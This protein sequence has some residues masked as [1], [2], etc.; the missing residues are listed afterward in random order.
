MK[1]F[2]KT[3]R[4]ESALLKFVPLVFLSCVSGGLAMQIEPSETHTS[5]HV[6][7]GGDDANSGSLEQPV[8]TLNRASVLVR[9]QTAAGLTAPLHV[10]LHEG[11]YELSRPLNMGAEDGGTETHPVVWEA[12][13][14]ET[15]VI[16]GGRLV[17]GWTV[18]TDGLWRCALPD[19][20]VPE[21]LY[22]DGKAALRA[23]MPG[24]GKQWRLAKAEISPSNDVRMADGISLV[25]AEGEFENWAVS[26]RVDVVVFKDWSTFRQ[27][28]ERIEPAD[29]RVVLKP[30]FG[31]FTKKGRDHNGINVPSRVVN[32]YGFLEGHP[33][34]IDQPGDWAVDTVRKEVVYRPMAGQRPDTV[35]AVVPILETLISVRGEQDRPVRNLHFRGLGVSYAAWYL[36]PHGMDVQQAACNAPSAA[37]IRGDSDECTLPAA[38]H[39][40]YAETCTVRQC[41]VSHHGANG[42][43][44]AEGCR[45]VLVEKNTVFDLGAN[46][47]MIGT[48]RAPL[49]K[50]RGLL[51]RDISVRHN[52]VHHSGRA[53]PGAIGIWQ[54]F[55]YGSKI[56]HNHVHHLPYTGISIGWRWDDKRTSAGENRVAF[57]HIHDVMLELGDG[58]GIYTLG[59]QPGSTI[60]GN[61]IHAVRRSKLNSASPN[62][63]LYFDQGSRGISAFGNTVYDVAATPIRFHQLGG[64]RVEV[65]DNV[66]VS[67]GGQA[68]G[69]CSPPYD[70][71][72]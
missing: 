59:A 15:V 63:G 40:A 16:S 47:I 46:A 71:P 2:V 30:P 62:N 68:A 54:G 13:A 5:I 29:R 34:F 9:K 25:F 50:G 48:R 33:D 44:I 60:E 65:H 70:H 52:N 19:G 24:K 36:P 56:E 66:L 28:V 18:G 7:V 69:S 31:V 32:F 12:A 6:A 61:I 4:Q 53:L 20:D 57:N 26:G 67:A 51:T 35:E 39:F 10:I 43:L 17:Y 3:Q 14:G 55:A 41:T 58:G 38:L 64:G 23:R 45:Q 21:Q 27:Q 72:Y 37:G 11:R 22:V 8:A 1:R 42:L 49:R